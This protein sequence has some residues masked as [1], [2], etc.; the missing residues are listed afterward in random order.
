MIVAYETSTDVCSVAFQNEQGEAFEK[1]TQGRG[2]HSD[3]VFLFTKELMQEHDFQI[4]DLSALLIS[5]GP[6]S[7]TGLRIG[8]SAIKGLLFQTQVPLYAAGSLAGFAAAISKPGCIHAIM[9]ARRTH[10]YHQ[11]FWKE[12]GQLIS[13][14]D[15]VLKE[16]QDF[17]AEVE[18][19]DSIIGTGLNRLGKETIEKTEIFDSNHISAKNLLT[20]FGSKS[21]SSFF[22]ETS[23]E[24]LD[25]I[26]LSNHQVNN[27]KL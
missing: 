20:L 23:V 3:H 21:R 17:E 1:R 16:I 26:Y 19:G 9:D 22:L 8:A 25:P 4:K 15:A 2:V 12:A 27:S 14:T 6:G 11:F 24:E 13:K 18:I 5:N 10:L 7:Y